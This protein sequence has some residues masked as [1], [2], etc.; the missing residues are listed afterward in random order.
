MNIRDYGDEKCPV[1]VILG[2]PYSRDADNG[3]IL[4]GGHGYNFK[5][6]W[7]LS[8]ADDPFITSLCS[9]LDAPID[10]TPVSGQL[11]AL[12]QRINNIQP[13]ILVILNDDLLTYFIPTT[14]QKTSKAIGKS[15]PMSKWAGSLLKSS[16]LTY[17]HYIIGSYAPDYIT[18]NWDQHEIQGFIDFGH[19]KEEWDYLK[20][21]GILNDLPIR[22]IVTNPTFDSLTDYLRWLLDSY[23]RGVLA[24]ISSDIETIRPKK[25]TLYHTIGHS[26]FTYTI[27]LAPSIREAIS[28]CFWDYP[29][30]QAIKIW[31]LLN[32]VLTKIPQIGQNY[33]SFDSHHLEALGFRLIL[34]ACSD[35]LLR[36]H[37][38]WPGLPHK[39]QFQTK[40][41]TREPYY[42]DEGKNW[43]SKQKHQLMKYNCLDSM[44]TYEIWQKQEEEFNDR[45]HLR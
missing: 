12:L 17:P 42:K 21:H 39:L 1:W 35:T 44:V 38:L 29:T 41:Y 22:S 32:E 23:D 43:S 33:Y 11:S 34:P 15:S 37:T 5:K 14:K 25:N 10:M 24:Y 31:R 9:D 3:Y 6:T 13:K 2:Q 26:G 45:P 4:S 7:K 28:F 19:V 30:D 40:Q 36:H 27:S 18:M 8:G 20:Q 16:L